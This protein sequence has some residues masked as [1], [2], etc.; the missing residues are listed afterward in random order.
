MNE[1]NKAIY[2]I[3]GFILI[4]L[5]INSQSKDWQGYAYPDKNNLSNV[6]DVGKHKTEDDCN[7]AAINALLRNGSNTRIGDYECDKE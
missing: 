1:N 5:L 4:A 7:N 6:I 3:G 2:W